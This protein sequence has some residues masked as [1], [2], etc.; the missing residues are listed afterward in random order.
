MTILCFQLSMPNNNSW[1]GKWTGDGVFYAK[2]RTVSE[3]EKA[4]K[5][6]EKGY[7]SHSFGDGWRAVVHVRKITAAER[8]KIDKNT[9]G[10]CGYEW[11]IDSIIKWGEIYAEEPE[12][13]AL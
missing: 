10:F 4:N 7:Y 2:T 8:K 3:R 12:R 11:M 9:R 13:M 5:I 1:N 6:A